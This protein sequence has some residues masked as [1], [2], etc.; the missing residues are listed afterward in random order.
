MK[1]TGRMH[2]KDP[3]TNRKEV[4]NE[5]LRISILELMELSHCQHE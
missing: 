2:R 4:D 5:S 3:T 1:L